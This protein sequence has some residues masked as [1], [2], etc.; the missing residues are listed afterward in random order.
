MLYVLPTRCIRT[1]QLQ[2]RSQSDQSRLKACK[3][4]STHFRL[5]LV[6]ETADAF[7]LARA[8]SIELKVLHVS[9]SLSIIK[10][11]NITQIKN[12]EKDEVYYIQRINN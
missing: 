5:H 6:N 4:G 3:F 2:M 7:V 8:G 12:N 10:S 1:A 9:P 11:D